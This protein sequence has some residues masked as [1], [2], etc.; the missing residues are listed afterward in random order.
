MM[1]ID[2]QTIGKIIDWMKLECPIK[3]EFRPNS[4]KWMR[5]YH[6]AQINSKGKIKHHK[7]VIYM[8]DFQDETRNLMTLICHELI[9]AWQAE[10]I[11]AGKFENTI[12]THGLE[13][14]FAAAFMKDWVNSQQITG[15]GKI[16]D[17]E[18]DD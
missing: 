6:Q 18:L 12:E 2:F 15:I 9:H 11:Q 4:H 13:F 8:G 5:A 7:I 16:Y 3:Y 14:Q 10:Y 1:Q 17:P